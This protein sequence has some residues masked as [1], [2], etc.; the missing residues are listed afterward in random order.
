MIFYGRYFK[1]C[2]LSTIPSKLI[3]TCETYQLSRLLLHFVIFVFLHLLPVTLTDCRKRPKTLTI[4]FPKRYSPTR[5]EQFDKPNDNELQ[6]GQVALLQSHH[7]GPQHGWGRKS[8]RHQFVERNGTTMWLVPPWRWAALRKQF[9]LERNWP[10][11]P[12]VQNL[13]DGSQNRTQ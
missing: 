6:K 9:R 12:L 11:P 3:K 13:V 1:G 4:F 7:G 2:F 10:K 8:Q 5:H